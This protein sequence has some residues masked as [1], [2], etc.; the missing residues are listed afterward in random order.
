MGGVVEEAF[1]ERKDMKEESGYNL[2]IVSMP[3]VSEAFLPDIWVFTS[4]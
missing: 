1:S 2:V 3:V 4:L